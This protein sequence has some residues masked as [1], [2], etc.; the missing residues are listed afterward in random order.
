M[1]RDERHT[2]VSLVTFEPA[3]ERAF[4]HWSMAYIGTKS[5]LNARYGAIAE[6]SGFDPSLMNGQAVFEYLRMLA[7]KEEAQAAQH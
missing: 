7:H 4:G 1:K 3:A 6:E 2:N 5:E